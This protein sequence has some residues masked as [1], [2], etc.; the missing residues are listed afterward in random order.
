MLNVALVLNSKMVP[1]K[2]ILRDIWYQT[3]KH[4]WSGQ[5]KTIDGKNWPHAVLRRLKWSEGQICS[6]S[7]PTKYI[8][9]FAVCAF[10]GDKKDPRIATITL[11]KKVP[12]KTILQKF[13]GKNWID[14]ALLLLKCTKKLLQVSRSKLRY[15]LPENLWKLE[16]IKKDQS[17]RLTTAGPSKKARYC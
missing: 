3:N 17:N 9:L 15:L 16:S 14:V 5:A 2:T 6:T 8:T 13:D 10:F 11:D 12:L 7:N 4:W 1:P